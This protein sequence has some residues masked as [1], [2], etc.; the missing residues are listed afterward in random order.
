MGGTLV[1]RNPGLDRL[2]M[3]SLGRICDFLDVMAVRAVLTCATVTCFS[4]LQAG[5]PACLRAFMLAQ[6]HAFEAVRMCPSPIEGWM[7][8]RPRCSSPFCC[9]DT[10]LWVPTRE[11]VGGSADTGVLG[12][13]D[14]CDSSWG[15]KSMR[16]HVR[17][18]GIDF[19]GCSVDCGR[20]IRQLLK[21]RGDRR[22]RVAVASR[23][24]VA[25]SDGSRIPN[26]YRLLGEITRLRFLSTDSSG[27]A[28]FVLERG[29]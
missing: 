23:C 22:A 6:R 18:K 15:S 13:F 26:S 8:F 4:A 28:S 24:R 9:H 5:L 17:D 2:D 14:N 16:A 7:E 10:G 19:V 21:I 27:V 20:A 11:E 3:A 29:G 1:M 25:A 12:E